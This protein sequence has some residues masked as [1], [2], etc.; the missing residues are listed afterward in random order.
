[1]TTE[2]MREQ[3]TVAMTYDTAALWSHNANRKSKFT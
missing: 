2:Y 1:M 3:P